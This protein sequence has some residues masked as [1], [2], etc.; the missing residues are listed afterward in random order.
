MRADLWGD[1]HRVDRASLPTLTEMVMDQLQMGKP[2]VSDEVI[3]ES[4]KTQL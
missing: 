1:K 2:P 3:I 4:Y